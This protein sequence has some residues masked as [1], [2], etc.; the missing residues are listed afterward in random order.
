[1]SDF[2]VGWTYFESLLWT[3]DYIMGGL[4]LY[5]VFKNRK[6]RFG[7]GGLLGRGQRGYLSRARRSIASFVALPC[8][9]RGFLSLSFKKK[10]A[11]KKSFER[12]APVR[13]ISFSRLGPRVPRVLRPSRRRRRR[14]HPLCRRP[15]RDLSRPPS[16]ASP[17]CGG[18]PPLR[19]RSLRPGR[20]QPI[21]VFGR[22]D[23]LFE[24]DVHPRVA[25]HEVAVVR[26]AVLELHELF[27]GE[28]RRGELGVI[29]TGGAR[30]DAG[31]GRDRA[32]LGER[33]ESGSRA[34]ERVATRHGVTL[35]RLEERQR[36]H[37][38]RPSPFA[39]IN[40]NPLLFSNALLGG[41]AIDDLTRVAAT[42]AT[43]VHS[44]AV[45][46]ACVR[47]KRRL[48]VVFATRSPRA[49]RQ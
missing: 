44:R 27:F 36:Q 21:A 38:E 11:A 47:V 41:R 19:G 33:I 26:L 25:R 1:M 6:D 2:W 37:R 22:A 46:R 39:L 20:T 14:V 43:E 15:A 29:A 16:A 9:P 32:G 23:D 30:G 5:W 40:N 12:A 28:G 49:A 45:P 31:R 34:D 7:N 17:S 10:P 4:A 3:V 24:V 13:Q 8:P 18:S 35:S 48:R 42:C